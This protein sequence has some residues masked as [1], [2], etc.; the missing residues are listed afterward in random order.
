MI[1]A[2]TLTAVGLVAVGAITQLFGYRLGGTIAVPVLAVY[3]VK[4]ALM[5]P[6][7]LLS[8]VL[9]Y[10]ALG[11]SL[12][13]A[14]VPTYFA[15][16]GPEAPPR[17]HLSEAVFTALA[18]TGPGPVF[19]GPGRL[20][21]RCRTLRNRRGDPLRGLPVVLRRAGPFF[22]ACPPRGPGRRVAGSP[23]STRA[24]RVWLPSRTD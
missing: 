18:R 16:P 5:L 4:N 14:F 19:P 21:R 12:V 6:I 20:R 24:A 8:T 9:A 11:Y 7:F 17:E 3:T 1:L 23:S 2:A 15:F 13:V 10:L 22:G